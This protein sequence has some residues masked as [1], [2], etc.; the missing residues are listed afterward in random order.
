MMDSAHWNTFTNFIAI[1][2]DI[3]SSLPRFELAKI[4]AGILIF[5]YLKSVSRLLL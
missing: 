1:L 2:D 4:I 5:Y 3:S